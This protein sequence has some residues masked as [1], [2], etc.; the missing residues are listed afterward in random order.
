MITAD[1]RTAVAKTTLALNFSTA[2]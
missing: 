1:K 2:Q